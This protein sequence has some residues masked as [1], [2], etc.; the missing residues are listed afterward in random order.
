MSTEKSKTNTSFTKKFWNFIFGGIG[1]VVLFF[2]LVNF[3]IF[4]EMPD[5]KELENPRA[6]LTT[7]VYSED[8]IMLGRYYKENRKIVKRSEIAKCAFDALIATEDVRF[9]KHAGID[10]RSLGRAIFGLGQDG[11]GSTITQQLAKNLFTRKDKDKYSSSNKLSRIMQKFKEWIIALRLERRY[12]KDEIITM[13]LNIVPFSGHSF[14]IWAASK[15]F[16]NKHPKDL[17]IE[18]AAVLVGMLKGNSKYNPKSNPENSLNRR[19]TVLDQMMTYHYLEAEKGLKLKKTKIELDYQPIIDD[20]IGIYFRDALAQHLQPWCKEKGLDLYES[21]LRIYTTINY[22]AQKIAEAAVQKQM[23]KL[24]K[25]FHAVWG[26][27]NPWIFIDNKYKG[28]EIPNFVE[29]NLKKTDRYKELKEKFDGDSAKIFKELKKPIR[30]TVFSY[31]GDIDT[32][33]SV[34]DSMRYIKTFLHAGFIAIEPESGY[35]KAWVGG[36]NHKHFK[37]D[38]VN[39]TARRQV[40]STFKPIVYATAIDYGGAT[41]CD[42]YPRLKTIFRCGDPWSP[43]NSDGSAGGSMDMAKGLAYS[44]NLITAQV[45]KSIGRDCE[46]PKLVIKL[47]E[48]MGIEKGKIPPYPSLCMGSMEL[49]PLEMAGAYTA[50]VNKGL[51]VEPT[52]IVRI[53]DKDGNILMD[54][55]E[56]KTDQVLNEEKAYVMCK[57]LK[58]VVDFGTAATLKSYVKP[59]GSEYYLG[60][61]TGTT[62]G[63]GDGWFMGVTKKLVC[64]TWVGGD[65]PNIRFLNTFYGQGAMTALP[66]YGEFMRN[67]LNEKSLNLDLEPIEKPKNPGSLLEECERID[68]NTGGFTPKGASSIEGFGGNVIEDDG[69]E[70]AGNMDGD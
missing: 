46:A 34:Y 67:A 8:G 54:A 49:S 26:K 13:Y 59:E 65:V 27:R 43:S 33:M 5:I 14:G 63:N 70:G 11:G 21:G 12:T 6:A 17:R 40:G 25:T 62:Q 39:K 53:E 35:V 57:L 24:Q 1:F 69:E 3:G 51:W 45:M 32:V 28:M 52:F 38:H 55:P 30:M 42:V 29:N 22:K 9:E 58:G 48:R 68:P 61:K 18:E 31:R 7:E 60:G 16:F 44:D 66:I 20:G 37:Y 36:V 19:N 56:Q 4:G 2:L 47:A 10:V 64:A 15:E 23:A 50:F 41:P